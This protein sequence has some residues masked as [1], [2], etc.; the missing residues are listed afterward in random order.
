MAGRISE[1]MMLDMVAALARTAHDNG[2]EFMEAG[3]RMLLRCSRF[4]PAT[5]SNLV[6]AAALLLACVPMTEPRAGRDV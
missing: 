1:T 6:Q 2:Y 5:R 3:L 4:S